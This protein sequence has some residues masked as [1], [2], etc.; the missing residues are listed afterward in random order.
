MMEELPYPCFPLVGQSLAIR[1]VCQW[2]RRVAPTEAS[3]LL[4]GEPGTGKA[5]VARLIHDRSRRRGRPL[6]AVDC[7]LGEELEARLEPFDGTLFLDE[8]GSLGEAQQLR[9][10]KVLEEWHGRPDPAARPRVIAASR[11]DLAVMAAAGAFREDL[12]FRL[13]VVPLRLPPLRERLEDLPAL[14]EAILN[15]LRERNGTTGP[16]GLAPGALERLRR[17]CWPGNV[18]ELEAVIEYAFVS[19]RG[20]LI[21]EGDLPEALRSGGETNIKL[22]NCLADAERRTLVRALRSSRTAAEAAERLGLSRATLF[23]KLR[24]YGL[25]IAELQSPGQ[26]RS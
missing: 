25:S 15:R 12:Y 24:R 7:R 17:H 6:V 14:V 9:L 23:R 5:L 4:E 11:Q 2:V 26:S 22:G 1:T 3:V 10:L 8:A 16:K 20:E 19:A 13:A 21:E 18:R